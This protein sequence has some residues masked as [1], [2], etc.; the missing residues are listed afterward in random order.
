MEFSR[1]SVSDIRIGNSHLLK[2][3]FSNKQATKIDKTFTVVMTV[4]TYCQIDG[5][6]F[7]KFC[8]LLRKHKL[9]LMGNSLLLIRIP[10]HFLGIL[11]CLSQCVV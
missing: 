10:S 5:E 11:F 1:E 4:T 6:N 7:V 3:M 2:F 8:G 9:Y